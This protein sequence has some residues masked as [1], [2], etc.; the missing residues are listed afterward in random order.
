[1]GYG[2]DQ[3]RGLGA[4]QVVTAAAYGASPVGEEKLDS[5][6]LGSGHRADA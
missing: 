2:V 4:E 6:E 5:A 1:M 3:Q